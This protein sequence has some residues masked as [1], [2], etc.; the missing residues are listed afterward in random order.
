MCVLCSSRVENEC[1]TPPPARPRSL[2]RSLVRWFVG[3]FV[4]AP[5]HKEACKF[6]EACAKQAIANG[7]IVD[8]FAMSLDQVR[9][10]EGSPSARL[11]RRL[12]L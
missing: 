12:V 6:Y 9:T 5:L 4:Q 8:V 3:W 2:A 7:H 1:A 11:P 10:G